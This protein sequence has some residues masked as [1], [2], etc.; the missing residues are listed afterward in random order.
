MCIYIYIYIYIIHIYIY[1]W[2]LDLNSLFLER[3]FFAKKKSLSRNFRDPH[4]AA[5][6]TRTTPFTSRNWNCESRRMSRTTNTMLL[7]APIIIPMP[8]RQVCCIEHRKATA[9][10][11]FAPARI[12]RM[13]TMGALGSCVVCHMEF[14]IKLQVDATLWWFMSRSATASRSQILAALAW[15]PLV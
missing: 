3:P 6:L 11:K 10:L 13:R 14:P 4:R 9:P 8:C 7:V 12:A 2:P 15:L 5:T 1:I